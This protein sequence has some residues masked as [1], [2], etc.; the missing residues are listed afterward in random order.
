MSTLYWIWKIYTC[1]QLNK[2]LDQEYYGTNVPFEYRVPN[3]AF[4]GAAQNCQSQPGVYDCGCLDSG[5]SIQGLRMPGQYE[6]LMSA[7]VNQAQLEQFHTFVGVA[8]WPRMSQ[9]SPVFFR[10]PLNTDAIAFAQVSVFVPR[11]RYLYYAPWLP[12]G[13]PWLHQSGTNQFGQPVYANNYDP[14]PQHWDQVN[15]RWVAVWDITNQNWIAKLS[16]A[17]NDSV[18]SILQSP[19]AQQFA[20]AVRVPSLGGLS[21]YSMRQINT[22]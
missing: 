6:Q 19:L 4:V 14:W 15:Q 20:P 1:G 16:P 3:N 22:H 18:V 10:Y 8:Y 11:A 9:T 2:L 17:T 5:T 12:P 13:P 21:P 7:N